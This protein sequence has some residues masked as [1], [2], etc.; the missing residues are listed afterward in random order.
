[1][2]TK[3]ELKAL[4]EKVE[5]LNKKLMELTDEELSQV[6]GGDGADNAAF[7]C[8]YEPNIMLYRASPSAYLLIDT[9]TGYQR[10]VEN[11]RDLEDAACE[12]KKLR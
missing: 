4:K 2:K 3:E 11:A 5:A 8:E 9:L 1:M 12:L 7:L 6:S 10:T